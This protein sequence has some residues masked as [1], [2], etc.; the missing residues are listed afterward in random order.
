MPFLCS[1]RLLA[2]S[3]SSPSERLDCSE[4]GNTGRRTNW[5]YRL[6]RDGRPFSFRQINGVRGLWGF[7]SGAKVREPRS[8]SLSFLPA[9]SAVN[10]TVPPIL[11]PFGPILR[12]ESAMAA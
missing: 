4:G 5:T 10:L 7:V 2:P 11:G 12:K 3:P 1:V 9:Q 8:G 6:L